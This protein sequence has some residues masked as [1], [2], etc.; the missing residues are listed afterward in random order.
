MR[1]QHYRAASPSQAELLA[2]FSRQMADVARGDLLRKLRKRQRWSQE[3]A[4]FK[5]GVT[6]KSWRSWEAGGAIKWPN[7]QRLG[8]LF[9]I[10]P[11]QLVTRKD[12][13]DDTELPS[14]IGPGAGELLEAVGALE[15]KMDQ[16]LERV[17]ALATVVEEQGAQLDRQDKMLRSLQRGRA[18]KS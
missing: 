14:I 7:A 6:A 12:D 11:E 9:E 10:D 2:R 8:E 17:A 16:V 13:E 15:G 4:A 3:T 18:K 5:A 1:T